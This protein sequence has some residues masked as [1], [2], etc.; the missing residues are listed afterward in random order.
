MRQYQESQIEDV[1]AIVRR[2]RG[3][4][5]SLHPGR[6]SEAQ[7]VMCSVEHEL[8]DL[9]AADNPGECDCQMEEHLGS[10]NLTGGFNR[11]QFLTA[12]RLES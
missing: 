8:A 7:A 3:Y 4:H 11:E 1:V 6:R 5:E 2:I 9:F 10:C 12:C